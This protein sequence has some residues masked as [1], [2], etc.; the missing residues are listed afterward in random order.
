MLQPV[1]TSA[2]SMGPVPRKLVELLARQLKPFRL[3]GWNVRESRRWRASH[4][5]ATDRQRKH[6]Y[7][8][9]CSLKTCII[10]YEGFERTATPVNKGPPSP[11]PKFNTVTG[12]TFR[13]TH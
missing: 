1:H 6:G 9:T 12:A 11:P 2:R 10:L 3:A 5:H 4:Q 8:C 13:V 7:T